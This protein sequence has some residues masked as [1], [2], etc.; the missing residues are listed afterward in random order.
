MLR[1]GLLTT[2]LLNKEYQDKK[3][4]PLTIMLFCVSQLKSWM[5]L[6]YITQP[7]RYC[8]HNCLVSLTGD[9]VKKK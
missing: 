5:Y 8:E 3:G 1:G 9:Q 7:D 4:F 2:E 6:Y